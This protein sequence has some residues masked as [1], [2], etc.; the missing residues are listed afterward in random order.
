[1]DGAYFHKSLRGIFE[2]LLEGRNRPQ[3]AER[4]TD[5][6]KLDITTTD[7]EGEARRFRDEWGRGPGGVRVP[8]ALPVS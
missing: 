4:L 3:H 5:V 6:V 1:M 7:V 2:E 8:A